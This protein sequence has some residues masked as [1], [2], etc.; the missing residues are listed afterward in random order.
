MGVCRG[1]AELQCWKDVKGKE[2]S[3]REKPSLQGLEKICG[4]DDG[5]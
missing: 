3:L 2:K 1:A 5:W 4:D